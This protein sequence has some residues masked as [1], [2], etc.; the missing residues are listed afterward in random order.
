MKLQ[1]KTER[2]TKERRRQRQLDNIVCLRDI[3]LKV[4]KGQFVCIIGRTGSG[5]SSLLSAICGELLPVPQRLVDFYRGAEGPDRELNDDEA[6]TFMADLIE[7]A[8]KANPV[9]L[10]GTVAYTAQSPWIRN[11]KIRDNIIY[12]KP[13]DP[14]RYVDTI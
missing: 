8:S 11:K 9:E 6:T 4:R 10:N 13:F 3:T 14:E 2:R 7:N 12:D 1:G 5:K